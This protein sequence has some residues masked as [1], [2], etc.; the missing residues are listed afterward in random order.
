[1]LFIIKSSV[2]HRQKQETEQCDAS[3][4]HLPHNEFVLG[5]QITRM[6]K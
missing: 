3:T 4:A 6:R 1:M 5:I 2:N